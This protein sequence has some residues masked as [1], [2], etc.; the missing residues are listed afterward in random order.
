MQHNNIF[1][2]FVDFDGT[3][4][5]K[6]VGEELFIE[7][8]NREFSKRLIEDWNNDLIDPRVGWKS[9]CD[10]VLKADKKLMQNYLRQ[11]EIDPTF[12]NFIHYTT[13]NEFDVK[14]ISDGF[15][16][17]INSILEKENITGIEVSSNILAFTSENR[18]IPIFPNS[19]EDCRCSANCKRNFVLNNSSDD[20]FTIYIGDGV[21]DRCP[22]QYCDFIFA[23][24]SLLKFCEINRITYFPY[25][26]F[27]DVIKK[28]DEL[29]SKK[30]LKKR[31]QAEL[32]RKEVYIQEA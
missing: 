28:L 18:L 23:K 31:Y 30:R 16:F 1:K 25:S 13:E 32:K 9:L 26:S 3:I 21:S 24:D 4:T 2:I 22:V 8:G 11:I 17:Y 29:K 27:E 14:I 20:E 15:D 12:H 10:S 19:A 5:K 7:F 6:D